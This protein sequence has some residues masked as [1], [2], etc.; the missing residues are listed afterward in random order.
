M[1]LGSNLSK[2]INAQWEMVLRLEYCSVAS[3]KLQAENMCD[4]CNWPLF[5]YGTVKPYTY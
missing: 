2:V 1:Y 5:L 4:N 3:L